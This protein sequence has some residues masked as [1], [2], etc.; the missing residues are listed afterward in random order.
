MSRLAKQFVSSL[1]VPQTDN[2]EQLILNLNNTLLDLNQQLSQLN[3]ALSVDNT[4]GASLVT[5][6]T[7]FTLKHGVYVAGAPAATGYV[8]MPTLDGTNRK[9][10]VG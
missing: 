5:I 2:I 10:L 1:P 4:A 6:N 8:I 9:Y 3:A 7:P